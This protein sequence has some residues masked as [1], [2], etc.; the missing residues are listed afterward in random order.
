LPRNP[1]KASLFLQVSPVY[2]NTNFYE[3]HTLFCKH[4]KRYATMETVVKQTT[5]RKLKSELLSD[6]GHR[7]FIEYNG[8]QGAFRVRAAAAQRLFFF[9]HESFQKTLFRNEYGLLL[10]QLAAAKPNSGLVRLDAKKFHFAINTELTQIT[11][12]QGTSTNPLL[13]CALDATADLQHLDS[14][15][16]FY[17]MQCLVFAFAWA[18]D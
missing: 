9:E 17:F 5:A 13:T 12:Y 16:R 2:Q 10:G 14:Q 3:S 4:A 8:D 7:L 6:Q 11:L 18:L 1:E 15:H